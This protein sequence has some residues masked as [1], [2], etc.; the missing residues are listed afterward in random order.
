[1]NKRSIKS[2]TAIA[3]AIVVLCGLSILIVAVQGYFTFLSP[4]KVGVLW[5][6]DLKVIQTWVAGGRVLGGASF[7][8]LITAFLMKSIK[9]LKSGILFPAG[10]V[11]VLY[12]CAL[13]F[14]IYHFCQSNVG[15]L[16]GTEQNLLFDTD[17][18]VIS[19]IIVAFAMIYKVAVKVSE[20]NSLTI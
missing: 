5:S 17:D 2:I 14:F 9:G 6:E 20:E 10:N 7:Y 15:L 3:V 12:L 1:M 18:L 16:T 13:A 19:F 11:P 8:A 4:D